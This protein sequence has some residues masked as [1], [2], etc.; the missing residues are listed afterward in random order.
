MFTYAYMDK[1]RDLVTGAAWGASGATSGR[2]DETYLGQKNQDTRLA[3]PHS[4]VEIWSLNGKRRLS[5]PWRGKAPDGQLGFRG[6]LRSTSCNQ[7]IFA[8]AQQFVT[9]ENKKF[10]FWG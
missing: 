8:P 5:V 2:L 3:F 1:R 4:V 7:R 10:F 9:R 6:L